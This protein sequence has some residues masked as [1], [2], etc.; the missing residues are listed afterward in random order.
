MT[1]GGAQIAG[2]AMGNLAAAAPPVRR[3]S[4]WQ[5]ASVRRLAVIVALVVL[6]QLGGLFMDKLFFATPIQTVAAFGEMF[7]TAGLPQAL[8]TTFWEL[9]AAFAIGVILGTAAGLLT[10]L[11]TFS[12]RAVLPILIVLFGIPQVTILPLI[13]MVAGIGPA[14]KVTFGVTHA[15]FPIALAIA[16]G[17]QNIDPTLLRAAKAGGASRAQVL[18]YVVFPHMV[19]SFFAG[20]RL[21]MVAAIIGVLLAELYVSTSGVGKYSRLFSDNFQAPQLFALVF[22]IAAM[23]VVI[24]GVMRRLEL[25]FS[26]WRAA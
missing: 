23:A 1:T 12:R 17:V 16:A 4:P 19:P 2:P 14:A 3:R 8:V 13:L 5:S 25:H 20:M 7:A 6:W 21:A 10:G 9:C 26:R 15:F 22:T 24:N 18:R 11:Q